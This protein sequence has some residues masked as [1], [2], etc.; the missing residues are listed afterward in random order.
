MNAQEKAFLDL[1]RP[2]IVAN[3]SKT[4]E[5]TQQPGISEYNSH[6][7]I[8]N[9]VPSGKRDICRYIRTEIPALRAITLKY[10]SSSRLALAYVWSFSL[11]W[12][13][14]IET[15]YGEVI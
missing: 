3:S 10:L 11:T 7:G 6:P 4:E 12:N 2:V 15:K 9:A 5:K 14:I 8:G 1:K 13:S